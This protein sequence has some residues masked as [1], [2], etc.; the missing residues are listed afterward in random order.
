MK[1]LTE[2]QK[3]KISPMMRQ[4]LKTKEEY[5]DCILM[6][7]LGD[8]Y[9]MFF[10]DAQIASR[11]LEI[12]LTGRD[13]GL[14]ERAPM[15]GIPYHSVTPYIAK[16]IQKGY[17]VAICDQTEDPKLAKGIV[18]RDVT[19]VVT[20]GTLTEEALLDEKSNNYL[21]VI[22]IRQKSAALV[23]SDISTGEMFATEV[24][25][26]TAILNETARYNPAEIIINSKNEIVLEK[27][28]QR[29]NASIDSSHENLFDSASAAKIILDHFKTDSL[30]SLGIEGR[31]DIITAAAAMLRYLFHTQKSTV[32]FVDVLTVYS[33]NDFMDLDIA[34]RRNLELT[35][36]L[37][38]NSR[39]GS[40][41][42]AIDKTRTAMG[43]RELR[44]WIEKPLLDAAAIESRL[45]GVEELAKTFELR[46]MAKEALDL[47]YD[48]SRIITR[49]ASGSVT[50]KDMLALRNTLKSLPIL[51]EIISSAK[52][53][54]IHNMH[55]NF[56][57]LKTLCEFLE[58]AVKDDAPAIIRDGNII[59]E[60]H[61][62]KVD[63]LRDIKSNGK[64]YLE[65]F[66]DSE[67]ERT[68]IPKLKLGY[69]KVFGYYIEITKSLADQAP[70]D[71]IRRQTLANNERFTTVE[72]KKIEE[73]IMSASDK[74]LS[75]EL[76]LYQQTI[77]KIM[78]YFDS[79]KQLADVLAE[80]DCLYSFAETAVKNNYVRPTI[81][82]SGLIEIRE[83]RHPVV[84]TMSRVFVPNDTLLDTDKNRLMI[85]TG[86]NMAGKSTYMRQTALITLMAQI[87]S[88]VPAKSAH[89]GIVD[90]IFTRVGASDDIASGQSTFMLEMTEVA[91]ILKT[92]TPRSLIILDEIGRGTST[93]DGLSI[94]WAVAEYVHDKKRLGAKTLF[95][96]HYHEMT[97]MEDTVEGVKNY[98]IAVKKKGDEIT[99]LRKI[100]R[101]GADRSYGIEVAAL[102]GVPKPVISS[103]KRILKHLEETMPKSDKPIFEQLIFDFDDCYDNDYTVDEDENIIDEPSAAEKIYE[104]LKALDVPSMTIMDAAQKLYELV[105]IAKGH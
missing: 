23:F 65:A 29:F 62:A 94:A 56:E 18:K 87:G 85:I 39:K 41:I 27:L 5:K 22:Y 66:I 40:L 77:D 25:S 98:N 31:E 84:E 68:G 82:N 99:F 24:S 74:L 76:E 7:R 67:R 59:K 8:F 14:E 79:L 75:L 81:D 64:K 53:E 13:C 46:D 95:A 51:R 38:D 57:S 100:V 1:Q 2:E 55:V 69:N 103:A 45:S 43:A 17:K 34:T 49:T 30:S 6:Y 89:I 47:T 61:N 16:L 19:R 21:A 63:E 58:S 33:V 60:G 102:A 35:G 12:S 96:T 54:K 52:S 80:L 48:I 3:N 78:E 15:C 105:D 26:I 71:Y 86:P 93:F 91:N 4:Y 10:D 90:R 37:R 83:G 73:E 32:P 72:L 92:A 36:T 97:E 42:G 20:P 101:G 50:P 88:F 11:E 70:E 44:R 104:E 28:S 9:E